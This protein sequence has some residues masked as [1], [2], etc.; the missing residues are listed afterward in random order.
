MQ[1][2]FLVSGDVK[3]GIEV[4]CPRV[5][6]SRYAHDAIYD[7]LYF[8]VQIASIPRP[9]TPN[10]AVQLACGALCARLLKFQR[11]QGDPGSIAR[12]VLS[13]REDFKPPLRA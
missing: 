13:Y 9:F 12:P 3:L 5:G 6:R 2:L 8:R 10:E 4:A 7:E 11:S 1:R